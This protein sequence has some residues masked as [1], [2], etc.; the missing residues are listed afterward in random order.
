M[1]SSV[2]DQLLIK[3]SHLIVLDN[4]AETFDAVEFAQ[5]FCELWNRWKFDTA[6]SELKSAVDELLRDSPFETHADQWPDH[7]IFLQDFSTSTL[8]RIYTK[9]GLACYA[10]TDGNIM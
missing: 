9:S 2:S 8:V 7:S 6:A 5:V 3:F 1:K 4:L 10:A